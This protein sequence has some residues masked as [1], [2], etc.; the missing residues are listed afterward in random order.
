MAQNLVFLTLI[1][2]S[3]TLHVSGLLFGYKK[4]KA[5]SFFY[6]C[7]DL[8]TRVPR[9][10]SGVRF[11]S[12]PSG[13][14]EVYCEMS[15][16]GGGYTFVSD[17][18]LSTMTQE[19]LNLLFRN[20]TDVLMRISK[21]DGSQPYTVVRQFNQR[22]GLRMYLN[23]KF[24]TQK[25]VNNHMGQFLY[26]DTIYGKS[27]HKGDINGIISNSKPVTYTTC[28]TGY[29]GHFAFFL[30][31]GE[32]KPNPS[33]SHLRVYEEGGVAVDWRGT[34]R[35]PYSGRR[36]PKN[37]FFFTELHFA[38]CGTYTSSDRWLSSRYPALGTAIGM[39]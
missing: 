4:S 14:Y 23:N 12:L 17:T 15:I 36:I 28:T 37:Y 22:K 5:E 25:P 35:R 24:L 33:H 39:R 7:A 27:F 32:Y 26:L 30:N 18:L 19:D 34:A 13:Y 20:R 8:K 10:Y 31:P 16:N 21:P 3:V 38:A 11:I 9:V 29:Q 6:T 2:L 1:C